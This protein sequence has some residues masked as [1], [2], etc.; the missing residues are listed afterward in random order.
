VFTERTSVGLDVHA[1]SVAAAAI[2]G[3]TGEVF[4]ARLVPA[5][6]EVIG[7]IKALPGPVAA[8]MALTEI[9]QGCSSKF[10]TW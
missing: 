2:D 3:V 9:P 10:P 1:R 6:R 4:R 8:V 5:P 7:W